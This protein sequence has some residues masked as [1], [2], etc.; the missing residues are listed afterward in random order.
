MIS[1]WKP[2][3]FNHFSYRGPVVYGLSGSADP[4]NF[5]RRTVRCW[6]SLDAIADRDMYYCTVQVFSSP[7]TLMLIP[8]LSLCLFHP[9]SGQA[10]PALV[11]ERRETT[12]CRVFPPNRGP[13]GR[14]CIELK[15]SI[16]DS[17][18]HDV[19]DTLAGT[20]RWSRWTHHCCL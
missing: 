6:M 7:N 15:R 1:S 5:P 16:I 17:D 12:P 9:T 2:C 19:A 20:I 10:D 8:R 11:F 14:R 4:A 3:F 18:T 13:R